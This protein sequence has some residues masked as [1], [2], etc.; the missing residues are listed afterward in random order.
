[1]SQNKSDSR[2]FKLTNFSPIGFKQVNYP[3]PYC[4]LCRGYLT[5]VCGTC[6]EKG[7]EECAVTKNNDSYYHAHCYT[8]MGSS[9]T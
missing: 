8:L 2:I 5:E 4:S 3:V 1:M 7:E 9:N 6:I